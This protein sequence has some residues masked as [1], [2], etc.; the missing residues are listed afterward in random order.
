MPIATPS[1]QSS[2]PA[3]ANQVGTVPSASAA[4]GVTV[5]ECGVG[6]VRQTVFT[7][8]AAVITITD[9]LAYANIQLYDFP[10]GRI[11]IMGCTSSLSFA[12]TSTIAST[13]NSGVTVSYGIGTAAASNTTLATTPIST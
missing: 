13:L 6:V 10:A 2:R 1:I 5:K 9:S 12:T 3:A 7:L 8:T 11:N 4:N